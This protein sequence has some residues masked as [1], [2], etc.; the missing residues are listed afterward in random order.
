MVNVGLKR[1]LI[2]IP[3][4]PPMQRILIRALTGAAI[5]LLC[6]GVAS[7]ETTATPIVIAQATAAPSPKPATPAFTY[8]GYLRSFYF[9][10]TNSSANTFKPYNFINQAAFNS[11]VSLHGALNLGGGFSIG[12][13]YLYANPFNN[14]DSPETHLP[15]QGNCS[16]K[17][18]PASAAAVTTPPQTTYDDTLPDYRLST[19]YEARL[20][21]TG[22]AVNAWVGQAP[23]NT[24]WAPSSDSRLKPASY[25]GGD[26]T[27]N[28]NPQWQV[29]GAYITSWEDRVE[30]DFLRSNILTQNGSYLDAGG[31]GNTGI[32]ST[33]GN[34]WIDTNGFAYG[35][36]GYGTGPFSA[37]GY[38]YAFNDIANALWFD[39][40]YTWKGATKPFVAFQG[41][42]E[43]NTGSVTANNITFVNGIAGKINSQVIGLQLGFTPFKNV[44]FAVGFND[45]PQ[46]QDTVTLP[47][48]VTCNSSNVIAGAN[49]SHPFPYFLPSNGP[50]CSNTTT[51]GVATVYY[52]GWASPYT[53]S[54]A[55]DPLF[56][57]MISQGMADRRAPGSAVKAGATINLDNKQIRL[58]VAHAWYQYGNATTTYAPTQETNIDGTYFFSNVPAKGPYHGFSIRHRYADRD[59]Y[60]AFIPNLGNPPVFKY[61]RTQLE[62]DF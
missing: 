36:V 25:R 41:G 26:I 40:K 62:Y 34:N 11:A 35:R 37:N 61:N 55:T 23:M 10:R 46:K 6:G 33:V 8:G 14:C 28:L 27:L 59:T 56:T 38:F 24:P 30:S 18:A 7:A 9:T 42:T 2:V 58:I 4:N 15:G 57:T 50:D 48:G 5:V 31:I 53:D 32:P 39:A 22:P 43:R 13:S 16:K 12:G 47:A 3:Y 44:D 1:A 45:I 17:G 21:Y 49:A 19:L 54:Y 51:P 60:S 52:G 20:M 29:E